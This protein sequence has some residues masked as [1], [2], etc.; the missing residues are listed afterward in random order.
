MVST[1]RWKFYYYENINGKEKRVEKEF[2]DPKKY[3]EFTKK[4][5]MPSFAS[6][7]GLGAP[8]KK[9]LSKKAVKKTNTTKR[10]KKAAKEK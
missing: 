5:P 9:A 3:A 8:V 10:T 2:N 6:F 1:F 4:H 7:F